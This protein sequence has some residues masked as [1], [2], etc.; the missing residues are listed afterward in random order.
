MCRRIHYCSSE[1]GESRD[2]L[3]TARNA[4]RFDCRNQA[5]QLDRR[6]S[7]LA[8]LPAV[9]ALIA[10]VCRIAVVNTSNKSMEIRAGFPVASVNSVPLVSKSSQDAAT[11]TSLFNGSKLCKV[12][13]EFKSIRCPIPPRTNSSCF[14]RWPNILI[15]LRLRLRCRHYKF[16]V[17]Q[18]RYW[19]CAFP[20]SAR[21][22]PAVR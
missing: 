8:A 6:D 12:L 7:E 4:G 15:S 11:A 13:H 21:P 3:T 10:N 9:C 16:D 2:C 20:P 19:R 1:I 5:A 22:P 18:D 17:S 14:R